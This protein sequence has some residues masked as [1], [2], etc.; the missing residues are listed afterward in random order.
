MISSSDGMNFHSITTFYFMLALSSLITSTILCIN[1]ATAISTKENALVFCKNE[2]SFIKL[3]CT[4]SYNIRPS[5]KQQ[6][7]SAMEEGW[8]IL[9]Q[10][11]HQ[12]NFLS[13]HEN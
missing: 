3:F 13:L 2:K 12:A 7:N 5:V 10:F 9:K 6:V 1:M 4:R 11:C 8:M